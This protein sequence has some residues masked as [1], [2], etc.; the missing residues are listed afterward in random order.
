MSVP[1]ASFLSPLGRSRDRAWLRY[2]LETRDLI[3]PPDHPPPPGTLALLDAQGDV[4][5]L[6]D[7][8]DVVYYVNRAYYQ[9]N[10]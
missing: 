9:F 4:R 3:K 2:A 8:E 10:K 6:E 5:P 7:V 1:L